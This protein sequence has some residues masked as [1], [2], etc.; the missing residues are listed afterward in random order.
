[1]GATI[2]LVGGSGGGKTTLMS[3][4]P[5]F[6]N[7][8][9]GEI[10]ID[11][12]AIS[13]LSLQELRSQ[14]SLVS[15]QVVLLNASVLTN[16]AFGEMHTASKDEV[17][18]AAKLANAH[19]FIMEME[20]GYETEIGDN[21]VRLSGGQRQRLAI[22][23]AILKHSPILILDEA[24]SALDNE[25]ERLI[26]DAMQTVTKGRT[27]FI[28]A[29]RL[30]TIENA[31]CILVLDKGRLVESGTHAELMQSKGKYFNLHAQALSHEA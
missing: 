11:D 18:K 2:A 26:Q 23:R 19:D 13:R 22:T 28:I 14:I 7:A 1:A 20:Q 16:L 8:S 15:Q 3:L 12:V 21:G 5:R 24:T 30:S 29:H 25:S 10:Y 6:Y 17:I 31:D 9:E 27:T 4:L